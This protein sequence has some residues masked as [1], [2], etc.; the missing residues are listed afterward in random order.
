SGVEGLTYGCGRSAPCSTWRLWQMMAQQR[1]VPRDALVVQGRSHPFEDR[2]D[3][4][5]AAD[6]HGDERI[7]AAGPAQFVQRFDGEDGARG[8]ER[9][10]EGDAAAVRVGPLRGQAEFAD[11]RECLRGESL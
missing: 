4:L 5:P 3:A 11:D 6:A 7:P 10:P 9:V 8:R 1:Q 2:R